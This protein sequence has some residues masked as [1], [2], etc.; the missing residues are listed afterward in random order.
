MDKNIRYI[1]R[2]K[3][4]F[5]MHCTTINREFCGYIDNI[6]A[7]RIFFRLHGSRALVIV[8]HDQI[9]WMAPSK[10]CWEQGFRESDCKEP[11]DPYEQ[12][13]EMMEG[14]KKYRLCEK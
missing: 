4:D 6:A 2:L 12:F 10:V 13:D 3:E 5:H 1:V 8:P 14:L 7:G 11:K 9:A